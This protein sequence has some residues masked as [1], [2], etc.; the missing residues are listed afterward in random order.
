MKI[1]RAHLT[2]TLSADKISSVKETHPVDRKDRGSRKRSLY[3]RKLCYSD[4]STD[5]T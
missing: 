3:L 5:I 4:V 2:P 1:L